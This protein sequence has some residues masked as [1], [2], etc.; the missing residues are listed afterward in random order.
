VICDEP[1]S[2][3]DVATQ[4]QLLDLLLSLR[5][6]LGVTLLFV[7]HDLAVVDH[8]ADDVIV[9]QRG[10]IVESGPREQVLNNPQEGYTRHLLDALPGRTMASLLGGPTRDDR[11]PLQ[12][13]DG[14]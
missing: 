11:A 6:D 5:A 7:T 1:T 3:L 9:L 12:P 10:H 13:G 2:A 8:V 4:T 14:Q